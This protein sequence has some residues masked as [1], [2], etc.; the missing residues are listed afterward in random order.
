MVEQALGTNLPSNFPVIDR[1][2]N[3]VATSIKSLD[4]GAKTYQS[5]AALTRTVR[6]YIDKVAGFSGRTWGGVTVNGADIT[7][8][9][10]ELAVPAGGGSAAQHAALQSAVQYGKSVGVTVYI[11]P[12]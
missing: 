4:L 12:F 10:L 2:V 8:R 7:G 9:A 6:G 1:F 3:G 11:V 5:T